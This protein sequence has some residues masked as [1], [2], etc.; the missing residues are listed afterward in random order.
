MNLIGTRASDN[1]H[2]RA[3]KRLRARELLSRLTVFGPIAAPRLPAPD[4]HAH[5]VGT[6]E[7]PKPSAQEQKAR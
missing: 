1:L 5:R 6:A 4:A 7:P 3:S 2:Q